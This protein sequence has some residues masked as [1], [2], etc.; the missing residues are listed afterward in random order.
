[1]ESLEISIETDDRTLSRDY[2]GVARGTEIL[3]AGEGK[4]V[5]QGFKVRKG[6][7]PDLLSDVLV[8]IIDAAKNIEYGLIAAWLS[9]K[10]SDRP[11]PTRLVIRRKIVENVTPEGIERVIKEEI[12]GPVNRD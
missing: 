6:G 3:A 7:G 10:V 9:Q 2:M 1:M 4:L 5:Y 8:F 12:E 11:R